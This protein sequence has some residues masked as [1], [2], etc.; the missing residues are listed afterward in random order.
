M[1]VN[2]KLKEYIENTILKEYDKNDKGHA[3]DHIEY[4]IKRSFAFASTIPNINYDMV[5][6]IASYHDIA[7][8]IDAKNHEKLSAKILFEDKNL[9]NFFTEDEIKTMAYAVED[10][11]ASNNDE[12]RNIYGKIVSS[13]DRNTEIEVYLRRT[14]E[15]IKEHNE[16]DT[17]EQM[18][19]DSKQHMKNKFGKSGYATEKMYFE[20]KEYEKFLKD[21]DELVQDEELFRK[22]FIKVNGVCIKQKKL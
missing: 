14:Y 18:I 17:L 2:N 19:E 8:H 12:P 21:V 22:M 16:N 20:D 3:L 9:R 10:H 7:H 1:K 6:T 15:Y 4:V 5:Y 13:A 11:R